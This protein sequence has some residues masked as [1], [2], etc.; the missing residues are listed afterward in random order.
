M[1]QLSVK[2]LRHYHD[3]GLVVPHRVD[4]AT[5]YRFYTR[6]QVTTAQVVRRLRT[7]DMPVADVKSVLAANPEGRNAL[8]GEHL[9]RLEG[10]LAETRAAVEALRAILDRP[11]DGPSVDHRSVPA[12]A[13]IAVH[14]DVDRDVLPEWFFGAVTE[15]LAAVEEQALTRTGP[16]AGLYGFDVYAH[17]RGPA[18]VFVPVADGGLPTGRIDQFVVPAAELVVIEH[19]GPHD[20]VDL[21]YSQLGD[22]ATQ[23]EISVEA[24][25]REYYTCFSWDTDDSSQW[26]TEL[27]W[28]VFRSDRGVAR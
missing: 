8:I 3:V 14:A 17:D 2:T 13:S 5:G 10:Q 16:P 22:Y 19:H 9:G 15:L 27:C 6:E 20:D 21:V 26:V 11:H 4:P 12:V 24:P 28:P 1:T 25:L 23:H 18:T 7:L